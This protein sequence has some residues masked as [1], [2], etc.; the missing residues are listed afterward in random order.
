M[1]KTVRLAVL[2]VLT[3]CV[4]EPSI[5]EDTSPIVGGT[6]DTGDPGVVLLIH[7]NSGNESTCTGSLVAN[8]VVLTAAHCVQPDEDA[9][10]GGVDRWSV[11]IGYDFSKG[12]ELVPVAQ[13][14]PHPQYDG[15]SREHD[16]GVA[17]LAKPATTASPIAVNMKSVPT[18]FEGSETRLVGFGRTS[19]TISGNR[20][21]RQVISRIQRVEPATLYIGDDGRQSCKGDSGGPA[22]LMQSG[23][24]V[25][26]GTVSGGPDTCTQGGYYTRV[27]TQGAF[28]SKYL[29]QPP[30]PP[31]PPAGPGSAIGNEN[32]TGMTN[33][34][35]TVDPPSSRPPGE[36][37][38]P[39]LGGCTL[40]GP[41]P[42]V[43]GPLVLMFL[44]LASCI[45][46]VR[47][48]REPKKISR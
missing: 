34:G 2:C 24:E 14:V 47:R 1:N 6:V 12:G 17:I 3:G 45:R 29:S 37:P 7:E 43:G 31:T 13:V 46:I 32:M 35:A 5:G 48:C 19:A 44:W 40:A 36:G 27:D 15:K 33:P 21:K 30:A 16:V 26:V 10:P 39:T 23:R 38:A 20:I 11:F 41:A 4:A 42:R 18:S 28:L 22:F 25:I 8:N 9:P